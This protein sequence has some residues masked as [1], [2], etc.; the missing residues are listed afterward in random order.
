MRS[1]ARKLPNY[2]QI[3]MGEWVVVR[4]R[5]RHARFHNPSGEAVVKVRADGGL[6]T[7]G[8]RADYVVAHPEVVDVIIELKGSDV[9]KA[10]TQIRAT[11][12]VWRRCEWAGRKH[13]ALVVRG[14]GIH[15]KLLAQ[16]ER[17]QREFRKTLHMRLLIKTSNLDYEFE[18]FLLPEAEMHI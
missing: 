16:F 6:I 9:S 11:L 5:G 15:P 13:G 10:I 18:Q 4:E 7:E 2:V 17:W 8:E 3:E 14:K 1:D 12:P